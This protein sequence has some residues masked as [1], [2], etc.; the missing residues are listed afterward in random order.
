[1]GLPLLVLSMDDLKLKLLLQDAEDHMRRLSCRQRYEQ[2]TSRLPISALKAAGKELAI[3]EALIKIEKLW[4]ELTMDLADYKG[5]YLKLR[6][7]DDLYAAL[8]D[9]AVALSTMKAS[10]YAA[11]FL[12][13]LDTWEKSLSHISET[14]EMI[15]GVQRK[16]MYLESIFVGSEDI[17]LQLPEEAKRFDRIHVALGG[18]LPNSVLLSM[19][20]GGRGDSEEGQPQQAESN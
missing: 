6:S 1:M 3:E 20:Q 15:M 2:A 18:S 11:S 17:R 10:R 4:E 8:E 12:S 16:W 19:Q 5:E 14:V 13:Q 9:N 7:V